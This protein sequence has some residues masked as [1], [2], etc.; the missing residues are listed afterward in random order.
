MLYISCA[1]PPQEFFLASCGGNRDFGGESISEAL[2]PHELALDGCGGS[3]R[4]S[5]AARRA[6]GRS[7]FGESTALQCR[8]SGAWQCGET[9]IIM[10]YDMNLLK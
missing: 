5:S 3:Q 2:P 10:Q 7:K 6:V 1:V 8:G 9:C 4:E